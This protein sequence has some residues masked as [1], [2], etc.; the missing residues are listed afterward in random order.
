[1]A[2]AIKTVTCYWYPADKDVQLTKNFKVGEFHS[3]NYHVILVEQEL[4]KI[5]QT[6]RDEINAP[7]NV[8]SGYRTQEH[9]ASVGGS[10]NSAHLWGCAADIWTP[11]MK[12]PE[13]ARVLQ[14]TF[15]KSIAIGLHTPENY[16]HIDTLYRGNW[17]KESVSNIVTGF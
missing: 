12:S 10:T 4:L 1:M 6:L 9:N 16:C 3:R 14:S 17:Y 8:N 15:G 2:H 5:L 7:V 13:L 11:A